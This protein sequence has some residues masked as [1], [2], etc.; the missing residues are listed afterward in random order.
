MGREHTEQ[1]PERVDGGGPCRRNSLCIINEAGF[2]FSDAHL[3]FGR[4]IFALS[5]EGNLVR[6]D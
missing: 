4:E 2:F 6:R 5:S 1:Y 3:L